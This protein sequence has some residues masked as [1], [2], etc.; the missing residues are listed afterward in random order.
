MR[1]PDQPEAAAD[2]Y[3]GSAMAAGHPATDERGGAWVADHQAAVWRWLRALGAA[4]SLAEDLLQDTLIAGLGH[5]EQFAW[6]R[7][8]AR[9]WLFGTA[10]NLFLLHLRS[11]RRRD[12]RER[13]DPELLTNAAAGLAATA[14]DGASR[15]AA[16]AH[17]LEQLPTRSRQALQLRYGED[18]GR[19]VMSR[20]LG[21]Q[22][23]GVKSLLQRIRAALRTCMARRLEPDC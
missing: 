6:S 18:A 20:A 11:S 22:P 17:C 16:L 15:S 21:V 14:S 3:S 19:D 5:E 12:R 1:T 13:K 7:E 8:E 9:R 4:P 10:R 2:P 23:E